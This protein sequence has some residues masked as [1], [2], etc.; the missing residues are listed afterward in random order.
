[1]YNLYFFCAFLVGVGVVVMEEGQ[2]RLPFAPSFPALDH[3]LV[4]QTMALAWFLLFVLAFCDCRRV[5]MLFPPLVV[6]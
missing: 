3:T 4:P 2:V 6:A 1:M 5:Y